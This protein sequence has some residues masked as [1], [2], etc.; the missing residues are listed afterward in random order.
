MSK[1]EA[2]NKYRKN[3]YKQ[4]TFRI[5]NNNF[6]ELQNLAKEYGLSINGVI[7]HAIKK[8]YGVDLSK[9]DSE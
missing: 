8:T 3:N 1:Y 9:K 7:H 4:I 6:D 2:Q 5:R